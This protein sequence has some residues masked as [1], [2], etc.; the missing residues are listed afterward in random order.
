MKKHIKLILIIVLAVIA[1]FLLTVYFVTKNTRAA[2]ISAS[3][4]MEAF[5]ELHRIRSYDSLEQL[6]IKG[7]NKE[8]LEYVRN[9]VFFV[10]VEVAGCMPFT[11]ESSSLFLKVARE[12]SATPCVLP[13]HWH[14][15]AYEPTHNGWGFVD[16]YSG[17]SID[18]AELVSAELIAMSD[19]DLHD[20][21]IQVVRRKLQESD[22]QIQSW[23]SSLHF[24]PSIWFNDGAEKW[25]IVRSV[26]YPT[27]VAE[28]PENIDELVASFSKSG[29]RGFFAS[30]G[31]ANANDPFD[32]TGKNAMPLYRGHE[33]A[34]RFT[35]LEPL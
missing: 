27:L 24:D 22:N 20:F 26:R 13:M 17:S 8:A 31:V 2:F 18:P 4:D 35:G 21:G 1:T 25:V 29:A 16:P 33:L 5:N 3:Q 15:G 19:W 6:L 23:Q 30:V 10:F 12:V 32:P 14:R 9:Q 28:R 11:R 34:V 7:C